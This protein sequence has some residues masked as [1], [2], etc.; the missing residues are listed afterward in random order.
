MKKLFLFLF[1]FSILSSA[2]A[3]TFYFDKKFKVV[4]SATNA[5]YRAYVSD[6]SKPSKIVYEL[7]G[8]L[9]AEGIYV[10]GFF[11]P[12]VPEGKARIRTQMSAAHSAAD[13]DQAIAAFT[14]VGRT[15]G[16]V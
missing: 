7:E 2:T 13:I 4:N 10:S 14:S 1:S 12:V 16:I 3:Q 11:F 9:Y 8:K 5:K 15:L 6:P